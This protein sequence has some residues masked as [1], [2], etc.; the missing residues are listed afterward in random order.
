MGRRA[1]RVPRRTPSPSSARSPVMPATP[2]NAGPR[3]PP[4]PQRPNRP[5]AAC[6]TRSQLWSKADTS[7]KR[8]CRAGRA[9]ACL[10]TGTPFRQTGTIFRPRG[11]AFRTQTRQNRKQVPRHRKQ[12][13][14][15][16]NHIPQNQSLNQEGIKI[17][18][19]CP[20]GGTGTSK[21]LPGC[22][23]ISGK[24]TA[25]IAAGSSPPPRSA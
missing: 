4:F 24:V 1:G 13:P 21:F 25:T 5:T 8:S 9:F 11:T 6:A 23:P 22:L 16:R 17:F 14:A 15:S 18:P 7:K 10:W 20:P 2:A 12:V 3:R 19:P